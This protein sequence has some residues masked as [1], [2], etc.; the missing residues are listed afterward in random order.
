[1]ARTV[2][3]VE[4]TQLTAGDSWDW[5]ITYSDYPP[6]EGWSLSY[7]L[8]GAHES[9]ITITADPNDAESGYEVRVAAATTA[10]Y[11]AGRYNL[12][13]YATKAPDRFQVYSG[14]LVVL[15]DPATATPELS[16]AERMLVQVRARIEERLA[17]DVSGYTISQRQVQKE[18]L[19][20]LR[21]AEARYADA[22][23]RERGGGFFQS[24]KVE[25]GAPS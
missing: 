4:P 17:A 3:T 21:R 25:F 19:A 14:P 6:S 2:P 23:R 8:S 16:H 9:V 20:E 5:D 24:V 1:M 15:P 11:T 10:D 12:L 7:S 13:G 22:V 18:D